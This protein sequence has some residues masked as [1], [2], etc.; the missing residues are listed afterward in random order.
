MPRGLLLGE[1]RGRVRGARARAASLPLTEQVGAASAL[2][3]VR[4]ELSCAGTPRSARLLYIVKG[5]T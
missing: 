5:N 1:L 3:D 4:V 2:D